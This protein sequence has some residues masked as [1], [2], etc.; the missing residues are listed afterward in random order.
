[1]GNTYERDII[2][3][4]LESNQETIMVFKSKLMNS[5]INSI[6]MMAGEYNK[7]IIFGSIKEILFNK[8]KK[9]LVIE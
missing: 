6:N 8:N 5:Q 1:M 7:K 9:I 3:A 4:I 2:K